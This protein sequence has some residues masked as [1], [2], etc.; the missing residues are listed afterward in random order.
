MHKELQKSKKLV[1][2]SLSRIPSVIVD[3][4]KATKLL[5]DSITRDEK[6]YDNIVEEIR[7]LE[8]RLDEISRGMV[9]KQNEIT[10]NN[11]LKDSLTS[12]IHGGRN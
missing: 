8:N 9:L 12:F 10:K 6:L 11:K 4:D 1:Q 3:I 5:T 2:E 7:N